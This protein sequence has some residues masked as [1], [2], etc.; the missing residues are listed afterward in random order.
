[1][2][3]AGTWL[4]HPRL[5]AAVAAVESSPTARSVLEHSAQLKT[6][7]V[8][9]PVPANVGELFERL[10]EGTTASYQPTRNKMQFGFTF[11]SDGMTIPASTPTGKAARFDEGSDIEDGLVLVH[12]A[13]HRNQNRGF[14][15]IPGALFDSFSA[16]FAGAR[17]A[18]APSVDE[19]RAAAFMRG[20]ERRMLASEIE[21][22]RVEDLVGQELGQVARFHA[23]DGTY[24]GDGVVQ[25]QVGAGYASQDR[26]LAGGVWMTAGLFGSAAAY[27]LAAD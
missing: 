21:A 3:I 11:G 18:L 6:N 17:Q 8:F 14:R 7:V 13:V 9:E 20:F 24:L 16:P 1:M 25:A 2:N 22:Y 19:S 27:E 10:A 4:A 26:K 12:E 23:P 5:R 15:A